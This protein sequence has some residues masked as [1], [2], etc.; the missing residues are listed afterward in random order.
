MKPE[1]FHS[2]EGQLKESCPFSKAPSAQLSKVRHASCK[3]LS[4]VK[5]SSYQH[6]VSAASFS[7]AVLSLQVY[8]FLHHQANGVH[9]EKSST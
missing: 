9:L 3:K 1:G 5:S 4:P 7:V 2:S 6:A 8:F